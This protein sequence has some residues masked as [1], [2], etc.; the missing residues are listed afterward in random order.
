LRYGDPEHHLRLRLHGEPAALRDHA[1]LEFQQRRDWAKNGAAGYRREYPNA[2]NLES[3]IARRW[4][5]E[6]ADLAELL[7]DTGKHRYEPA[8]QVFRRRSEDIAP[9][10]TELTYR[11]QRGQLTQT[12]PHLLRSL[13]HLH[14]V[15][16]LRSAARTH[17]LVLLSFLD[18]HYA[19]YLARRRDTNDPGRPD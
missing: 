3:A 10:L 1:G 16:L 11:S 13:A 14:A 12:I 15:R 7:D 2:P 19:S 5:G 17:E 18:R 9:L 8:R 6:R 4:R